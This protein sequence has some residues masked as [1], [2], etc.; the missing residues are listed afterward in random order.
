MWIQNKKKLSHFSCGFI[1]QLIK[2]I[3]FIQHVSFT[4]QDNKFIQNNRKVYN[5]EFWWT[6]W[7]SL[8]RIKEIRDECLLTTTPFVSDTERWWRHTRV[9]GTVMSPWIHL[10][11]APFYVS[12][13][14]WI[15][16][17]LAYIRSWYLTPWRPVYR[18]MVFFIHGTPPIFLTFH[19]S[20]GMTRL[21]PIPCCRHLWSSCSTLLIGHLITESTTKVSFSR[22]YYWASIR[23]SIARW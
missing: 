20:G 15:R 5:I 22:R 13:D 8:I 3:Y 12:N 4:L 9:T 1:Y 19:Q 11:P 16:Q 10:F 14:N 2:L 21:V 18:N 17:L 7:K 23:L 6:K